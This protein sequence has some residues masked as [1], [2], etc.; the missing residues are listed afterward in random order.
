MRANKKRPDLPK[1]TSPEQCPHPRLGQ[2]PY[3]PNEECRDKVRYQEL[4]ESSGLKGIEL[5]YTFGKA[6]IDPHNRNLYQKLM[7]WDHKKDKSLYIHG[8][9]S[10]GNPQG[11]GTGKSYGLKCLTHRLCKEGTACI[12]I[13]ATDLMNEIKAS[14]GDD[15]KESEVAVI[16]SFINIPVLLIDDLGK[17]R[18][19]SD[20]DSEKILYILEHR[21]AMGRK[22]LTTS[23]FTLDEMEVRFDCEG[24]PPNFGPAIASR[25]GSDNWEIW[26]LGGPDRRLKR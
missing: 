5:T 6:I 22:T 16:S 25:I 3:C 23:N 2:C 10:K 20:W 12:F 7:K 1:Y 26:A 9:K 15:S 8:G 11:N 24:R 17:K 18:V 14:Y 19:K 13:R 21:E 4:L